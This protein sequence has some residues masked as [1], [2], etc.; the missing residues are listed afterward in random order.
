[1]VALDPARDDAPV[2][3]ETH[4]ARIPSNSVSH[5]I[6]QSE[7]PEMTGFMFCWMKL[8]WEVLVHRIGLVLQKPV[9][10]DYISRFFFDGICIAD[11]WATGALRAS[12][13]TDEVAL[14]GTTSL[15]TMSKG[16]IWF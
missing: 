16:K 13:L 7:I 5:V 9:A 8:A 6:S 11:L 2:A 14:T 15:K 4:F 12:P 1:M 3:S 10:R